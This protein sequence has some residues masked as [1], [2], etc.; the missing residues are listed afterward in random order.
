MHEIY[1][2]SCR[3]RLWLYQGIDRDVRLAQRWPRCH[4]RRPIDHTAAAARLTAR[5]ASDDRAQR[6]D[7]SPLLAR[8]ATG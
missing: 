5:S 7:S 8:N 2:P 1:C 3:F 6:A 4:A